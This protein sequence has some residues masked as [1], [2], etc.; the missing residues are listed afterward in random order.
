[1][2]QVGIYEQLITQLVSS[3]LDTNT[4]YVGDRALEQAEAALGLSRFLSRIFEYALGSVP[5][6]NDQ[7]QNQIELANQL[8]MWLKD[9][10]QD[11]DFIEENLI[12]SQGK[13]LT[14][15]YQLENP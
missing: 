8:L 12:H 15:L 7:L 9:R 1:M 2:L 10:I 4:F 13:I 3:R 6:G 14:A 11:D 5:T